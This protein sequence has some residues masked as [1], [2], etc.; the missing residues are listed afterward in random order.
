[1]IF[2]EYNLLFAAGRRDAG[3]RR[4]RSDTLG[5][6]MAKMFSCER[7][8]VS[9]TGPRGAEAWI[10]YKPSHAERRAA[11]GSS[12][13]TSDADRMTRVALRDVS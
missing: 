5:V 6:P 10:Q 2:S 3:Q 13:M 1:M 12:T 8:G 11:S 9:F 4:R 7:I